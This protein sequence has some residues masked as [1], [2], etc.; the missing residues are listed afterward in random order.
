MHIDKH[1]L[2]LERMA[3]ANPNMT[4]TEAIKILDV[5]Q[6]YSIRE[7]KVEHMMISIKYHSDKW[8][9]RFCFTKED[10][11]EIFKVVVTA[12]DFLK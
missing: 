8:N 2:T 10:D 9:E 3:N 12:F 5:N 7:V 1:N 11:M 6:D 4:K